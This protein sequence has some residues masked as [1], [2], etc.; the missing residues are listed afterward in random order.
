VRE[1]FQDHRAV[2]DFLV[3]WVNVDRKVFMGYPEMTVEFVR[4]VSF[5]LM[6]HIK[7]YFSTKCGSV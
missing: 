4:E 3:G 5:C 1:D 6:Y 2:L 7:S